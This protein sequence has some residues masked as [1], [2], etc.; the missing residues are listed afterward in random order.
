MI[1]L[2][3]ITTLLLSGCPQS[4][5]DN[6]WKLPD[7]RAACED[8]GYHEC[9]TSIGIDL[10]AR[11]GKNVYRAD[12][13]TLVFRTGPSEEFVLRNKPSDQYLSESYATG[14]LSE[15]PTSFESS[16]TKTSVMAS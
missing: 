7:L 13:E 1:L 6:E 14:G 16:T 12:E 8:V 10:I 3:A 5:V 2:S 15:G 9:I 4:Y 11:A